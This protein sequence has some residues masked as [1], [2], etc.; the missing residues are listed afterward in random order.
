MTSWEIFVISVSQKPKGSSH[1]W[2]HSHDSIEHGEPEKDPTESK[3]Q[4]KLFV[5]CILRT[6]F[7]SIFLTDISQKRSGVFLCEKGKGQMHSAEGLIWL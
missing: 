7:L 4:K 1:P 2:D 6:R 3:G 5:F